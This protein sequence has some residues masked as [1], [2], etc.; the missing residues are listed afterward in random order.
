MASTVD[1][2][3]AHEVAPRSPF[4]SPHGFGW[5]RY[6]TRI[7][8]FCACTGRRWVGHRCTSF[9]RLNMTRDQVWGSGVAINLGLGFLARRA[10]DLNCGAAFRR[11]RRNGRVWRC[12]I[13][14]SWQQGA[15]SRCH[16]RR[17][18]GMPHKSRIPP[19]KETVDCQD[20]ETSRTSTPVTVTC[21]SRGARVLRCTGWINGGKT[22]PHQPRPVGVSAAAAPDSAVLGSSATV[23][24][25]RAVCSM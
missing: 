17:I 10:R 25:S 14:L 20:E 11:L 15:E 19:A 22:M 13:G 1:G 16:G 6:H 18:V 9:V 23:L 21:E 12:P 7:Q 8:D 4:W 24:Q 2:C 3:R 5:A